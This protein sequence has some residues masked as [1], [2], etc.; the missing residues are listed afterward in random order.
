MPIA[1]CDQVSRD[2]IASAGIWI[3][4]SDLFLLRLITVSQLLEKIVQVASRVLQYLLNCLDARDKAHHTVVIWTGQG[5]VECKMEIETLFTIFRVFQQFVHDPKELKDHL[6]LT[7]IVTK[8]EDCV[9][10]RSI[11]RLESQRHRLNMGGEHKASVRFD[12]FDL[13][14]RHMRHLKAIK[15]HHIG[16]AAFFLHFVT[17]KLAFLLNFHVLLFL[18]ADR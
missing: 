8:L 15:R 1:N 12:W 3:N 14:I 18:N 10:F 7:H 9:N 17:Q 2:S 6:I 5:V 16:V 4:L 11:S 13:Y